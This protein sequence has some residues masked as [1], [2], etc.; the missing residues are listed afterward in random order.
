MKKESNQHPK[1][2]PVEESRKA[3]EAR[4]KQLEMEKEYLILGCILMFHRYLYL[5]N[6]HG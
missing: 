2:S 4:I 6:W 3:L 5:Y 1:Q